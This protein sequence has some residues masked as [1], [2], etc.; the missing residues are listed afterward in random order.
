MK[1]FSILLCLLAGCS[2][3]EV[4]KGLF[5]KLTLLVL[6]FSII[7]IIT[8]VI[9]RLFNK[10]IKYLELINLLLYL[11]FAGLFISLILAIAPMLR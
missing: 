3:I 6:V 2:S 8:W 1:K 4:G 9:A 11:G 10:K 5:E 7:L